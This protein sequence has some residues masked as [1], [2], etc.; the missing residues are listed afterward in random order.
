MLRRLGRDPEHLAGVWCGQRSG[1]EERSACANPADAIAPQ[2]SVEGLTGDAIP[3]RD[4]GHRGA[5]E[6]LV[7]R[8]ATPLHEPKLHQRDGPPSVPSSPTAKE[9]ARVTRGTPLNEV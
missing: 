6:D 1:L 2:P 3:S 9:V 4:L 5:L 8:L 7:D